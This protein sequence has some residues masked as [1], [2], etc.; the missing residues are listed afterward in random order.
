MIT[1]YLLGTLLFCL[2]SAVS[3]R[4]AEP[5]LG[6]E[7]AVAGYIRDLL[8]LNSDI[9]SLYETDRAFYFDQI[10]DELEKFVDFREV[11]RGVM[12]RYGTGPNGATPEQ[13]DRFSEVF[14]DSLIDFYGSALASYDGQSFEI[15]E[16][17]GPARE[18]E[19]AATV[20]MRVAE[21]DGSGF[22]I[23]YAMF[24]DPAGEWKLRNLYVEGINL[25]RQY[26]SRFDDLM[27]R[28]NYDIDAV[29]DSWHLVE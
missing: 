13:L 23:Q 3:V 27:S 5:E 4:A 6:A 22:E 11:A 2:A 9:R 8:A 26:Y 18:Q 17:R 7:E 24:V 1:R 14:K 16:S 21:D 10:E 25:R 29:I 20:R 19:N 28:N 15:L 12:A